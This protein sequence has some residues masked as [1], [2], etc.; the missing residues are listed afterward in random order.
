MGT[1]RIET[2]T[3]LLTQPGIPCLRR[4]LLKDHSELF[5]NPFEKFTLEVRDEK[6][7]T[8]KA[9]KSFVWKKFPSSETVETQR[10][11]I[12]TKKSASHPK[13]H[14]DRLSE[15]S[16]GKI[17]AENALEEAKFE[18]NPKKRVT[19]TR[20]DLRLLTESY[21]T[22]PMGVVEKSTLPTIKEESDS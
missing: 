22:F 8:P 16:W 20:Q 9:S 13:V 4:D 5:E 1:E 10:D 11:D 17:E 6:K 19:L 12:K 21:R 7:T 15:I 14:I 3:A 18:Y 2:G